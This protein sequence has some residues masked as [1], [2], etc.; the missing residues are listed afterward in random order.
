[1]SLKDELRQGTVRDL[2]ELSGLIRDDVNV[3]GIH[4][5]HGSRPFGQRLWVD[6]T[7]SIVDSERRVFCLGAGLTGDD[8]S[9]AWRRS[10]RR[11]GA[12]NGFRT[13]DEGEQFKTLMSHDKSNLMLRR[14]TIICNSSAYVY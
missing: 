12:T 14:V 3:D 5:I 1:M 9:I 8:G 6:W 10:K 7:S 11:L 13:T 4:K 2:I